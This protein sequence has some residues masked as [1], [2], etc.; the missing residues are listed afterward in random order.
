MS[1]EKRGEWRD[2]WYVVPHQVLFRDLD[3]FGHVNNAVFL[4][5]FEH[6]RTLLWFDITGLSGARDIGFIVARAE[7]DF[8][9]QIDFERIEIRV[10]VGEIRNSS[11]DWVYEIRKNNGTELAATGKVVVVLFDWARQSKLAIGDELRRKLSACS[12]QES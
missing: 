4:T 7:V 9:K 6:A 3:P 1:S 8:K 11:F 10:R 5:Y 2:G 12:R